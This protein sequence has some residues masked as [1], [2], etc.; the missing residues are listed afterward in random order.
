VL[1]EACAA[2]ARLEA[3]AGHRVNIG[4]NVSPRQLR[5]PGFTDLVR[6]TLAATGLTGGRLV[7]EITETALLGSDPATVAALADLK[8]L[9]AKL[10][11]DD[12]GTG[13]SSLSMVK[14]HPIDGIKIDRSFV[15]GLPSDERS[16]AIVSAVVGMAK[17]LGR[18]VTAEGIETAEQ[19]AFLK[20]VG[21][22]YGQGYLLGRPVPYAELE[23]RHGA[24]AAGE[25]R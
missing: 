16:A 18:R 19:L 10:A 12:F 15:Q 20:D 7:V 24:V 14:D 6:R 4:V 25:T 5:D 23:A 11:L 13:F 9:G 3:A 21:C 17:G 1:H 22:T 8:S 2:T